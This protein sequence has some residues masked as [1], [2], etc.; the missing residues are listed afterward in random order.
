MNQ[1]TGVLLL[2]KGNDN[3]EK[4]DMTKDAEARGAL[5]SHGHQDFKSQRKLGEIR[6][7][8][9]PFN[10]TTRAAPTVS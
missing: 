6:R 7:Q 8:I 9:P 5:N 10:T 1:P 4:Q 3:M 2:G